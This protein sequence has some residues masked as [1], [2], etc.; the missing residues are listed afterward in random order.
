M[1]RKTFLPLLKIHFKKAKDSND[2]KI[3]L[4]TTS[5]MSLQGPH[6]DLNLAMLRL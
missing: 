3:P 2:T 6:H 5:N 1:N 4:V